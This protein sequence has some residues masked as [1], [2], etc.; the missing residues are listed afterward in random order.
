MEL[1]PSILIGNGFNIAL[2][3]CINKIQLD[4]QSIS[5]EVRKR[6]RTQQDGLYEFLEKNQSECDLEL[7]LSI[8][9]NS[10]QCLKS[11]T[12]DYCICSNNF[13]DLLNSHRIKLKELVI[14]IMTDPIFHPEYKNIFYNCYLDNCKNNLSQFD[15][16]YT[17][18]YDLI[19]YWFLNN[20]RMLVETD[21][22]GEQTK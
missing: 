10:I 15:R 1:N 6:A 18:N 3:D 21:E 20:Q 14:Q 11:S 7:L 13:E 17:I 5:R 8:L 9:K 16:I 22:Q 2:S 19:L 4:Y 12:K